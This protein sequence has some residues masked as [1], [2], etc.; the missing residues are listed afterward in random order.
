MIWLFK[1]LGVPLTGQAITPIFCLALRLRSVPGK[2]ISVLSFT[3]AW[4]KILR[5]SFIGRLLRQ[6]HMGFSSF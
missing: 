2:R 1:I 5:V 4:L 6:V 3:R